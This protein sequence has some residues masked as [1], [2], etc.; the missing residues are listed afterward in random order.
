MKDAKLYRKILTISITRTF[1]EPRS[2]SIGSSPMENMRRMM[3]D[4]IS[5]STAGRCGTVSTNA[6]D[7]NVVIHSRPDNFGSRSCT[8]QYSHIIII[9]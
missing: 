8:C 9:I 3:V 6:A 4:R 5:M 7:T 2:I 1:S